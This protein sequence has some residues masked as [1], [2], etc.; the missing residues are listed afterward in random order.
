MAA[1]LASAARFRWVRAA[2]GR[3]PP[4]CRGQPFGRQFPGTRRVDPPLEARR[5]SETTTFTNL[6]HALEQAGRVQDAIDDAREGY[7]RARRLGL[8]QQ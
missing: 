4:W 8:D 6:G 2:T 5:N 1:T 7:Q 3:Q